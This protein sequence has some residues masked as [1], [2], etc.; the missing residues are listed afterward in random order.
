MRS[1]RFAGIILQYINGIG[2]MQQ[3]ILVGPAPSSYLCRGGYTAKILFPPPTIPHPVESNIISPDSES[4]SMVPNDTEL[5]IKAQKGDA[6]AFEELVQKYDR[7]VFT[8]AASYVSSAED[9]KDIYQEVFVRVYRSLPRFELRSEF[10]TWLYRITTN[11]CLTHRARNRR[12][13]HTSL[14]KEIGEED[15]Q[16]HSLKDTIKDESSTDGH[17]LNAEI[18]HHVEEALQILSPRQRMVFTLRHY[19]GYKLKEIAV[20]LKCGEG[21]VKKYLFEATMRMRRKL[22]NFIN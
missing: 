14:D 1:R 9:A 2:R 13:E 3:S 7:R 4:D 10:S 17:T 18:S 6:V 15:G 16:S 5:I 21:T 22:K 11:V 20:M 8:I 12:H 19:E